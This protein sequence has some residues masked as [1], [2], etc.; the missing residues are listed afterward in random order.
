MPHLIDNDNNR[1]ASFYE[2]YK[3]FLNGRLDN[4]YGTKSIAGKE[5]QHGQDIAYFD[6][7]YGRYLI[8]WSPRHHTEPYDVASNVSTGT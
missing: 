7:K 2:G 6:Y 4:P 8:D 3:A 5:Y 1:M